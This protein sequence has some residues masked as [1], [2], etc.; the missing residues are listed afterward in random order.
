M[1]TMEAPDFKYTFIM[2]YNLLV[3]KFTLSVSCASLGAAEM[4]N[5]EVGDHAIAEQIVPCGMCRMCNK[6]SYNMCKCHVTTVVHF[7]SP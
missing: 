2:Q 4:Y 5:L 7:A 1:I 3:I 6:G